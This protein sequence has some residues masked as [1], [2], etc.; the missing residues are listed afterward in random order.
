MQPIKSL[1]E[2]YQSIGTFD[3]STNF[4]A[5]VWLNVLGLGIFILSGFLFIEIL[6]WLRPQDGAVGLVTSL[7]E[8]PGIVQVVIVLVILYVGMILLHEALHG[9][10]FWLFTRQRPVFAFKGAYAYAAVPDWY[11]P[12]NLY[13]V[14]AVAPLVGISLL[15]VAAFAFAPAAWFLPVLVVLVA[16]AGG[17]AGDLWVAGWLLR[18]PASCYAQDKG[19]SVTLYLAGKTELSDQ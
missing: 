2:Y 13:F 11:L 3:L 8:L 4:R 18:Q 7:N 5:L 15:G 1:P 6:Y 16:N 10:F 14:T 9:L 12:R 19:D 17:A